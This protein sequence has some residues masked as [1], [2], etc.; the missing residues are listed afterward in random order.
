MQ[1]LLLLVTKNWNLLASD[2]ET[3]EVGKHL[4]CRRTYPF[5]EVDWSKQERPQSLIAAI[6]PLHCIEILYTL[7]IA[8]DQSWGVS[9]TREIFKIYK[10]KHKRNSAQHSNWYGV[11][12]HLTLYEHKNE[13]KCLNCRSDQKGHE[14]SGQFKF[15]KHSKKIRVLSFIFTALLTLFTKAGRALNN[16]YTES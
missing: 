15:V 2:C 14:H 4:D 6:A 13:M 5:S 7:I 3:R 1:R 16:N 8:P 9:P 12:F 10:K 11:Q